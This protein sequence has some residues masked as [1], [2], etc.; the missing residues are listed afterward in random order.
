ML[1]RTEESRGHNEGCVPRQGSWWQV[2]SRMDS[3]TDPKAGSGSLGEA[4]TAGVIVQ[5]AL[6]CFARRGYAA[7]SMREIARDVGIQPAS[8]YSHFTSKE[9]ILWSAYSRANQTLDQMQDEV[10]P[11]DRVGDAG[12]QQDLRAFIRTH[13]RFHAENGQ[14]A[15]IANSQMASLRADHYEKATVWRDSYEQRLRTLLEA[16]VD[17]GFA[18]VSDVKIYVYAILQMGMAI[19]TWFRTDGDWTVDEVVDRYDEMARRMLCMDQGSA[20]AS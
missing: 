12:P 20:G 4:E 14:I 2:P 16:A 7:T 8:I 10:L 13:A 15:M 17:A 5:V 19:A 11:G 1:A 18:N 9:E 6:D 3:R